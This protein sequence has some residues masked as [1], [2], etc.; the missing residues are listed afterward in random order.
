MCYRYIIY[1]SFLHFR[2]SARVTSSEYVADAAI[3]FTVFDEGARRYCPRSGDL[4]FDLSS[5]FI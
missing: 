3:Y 4:A 5:F 2:A 1:F